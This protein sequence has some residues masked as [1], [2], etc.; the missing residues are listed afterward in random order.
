MNRKSLAITLTTSLK[1]NAPQIPIQ[2]SKS[3]TLDPL[4]GSRS[5]RTGFSIAG[6]IDQDHTKSPQK[7]TEAGVYITKIDPT[8]AAAQAGLKPG[9][10]ILQCNG[11]DFTLVTHKKAVEYIKKYPVLDMLIIRKDDCVNV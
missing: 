7:F 8:G 3:P 5:L 1:W 11:H 10:R 2:V 9:D 4:T 6:G